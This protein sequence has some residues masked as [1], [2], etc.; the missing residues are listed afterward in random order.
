MGLWKNLAV[1]GL[2]ALHQQRADVC[3]WRGILMQAG[4]SRGCLLVC[5]RV[6]EREGERGREKQERGR[7]GE[8]ESKRKREKEVRERETGGERGGWQNMAE[9]TT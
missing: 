9:C 5:M 1:E 3:T 4:D 7:E 2:A 6:G 8:G